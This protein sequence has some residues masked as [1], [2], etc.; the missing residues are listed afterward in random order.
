MPMTRVLLIAA[1]DETIGVGQEMGVATM[2]Y[3]NPKL[4]NLSLSGVDMIV[5][6]M[7]E[8]D[9]NFLEKVYQRYHRI[10][11]TIAETARCVIRELSLADLDQLYEL[12][13]QEG[14]GRFTEPL[15]ER[16]E[17]ED[18][19]KAYIENMYRFYGYG[20][21]LIFSKENGELIGRAGIEHREYDGEIEPELGYL[22][23]PKY[24]RQG[25]A[26]EV[27][28]K[29]LEIAR[30]MTDFPRINCLI[31]EQNIPSIGLAEK[32]GFSFMAKME[33]DGR[34]MLRYVYNF[35]KTVE[36]NG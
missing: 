22:I 9:G 36:S 10:P 2:A 6:G 8:V 15:F 18:F 33:M 32:L 17:E 28:E 27:C 5:E 13:A 1:T 29:V 34:V 14:M 24:Q 26:S 16:Q 30:I 19:Q 7:E 21:W 3:A 23:G 20:M 12:Y 31:D 11:W 25:Y 4:P 35:E